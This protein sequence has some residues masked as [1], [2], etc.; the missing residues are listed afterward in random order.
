MPDGDAWG[1]TERLAADGGC[2]VS[3]GDLYGEDGAGHV[4]V[5]LV[6]PLDRLEL[7]AERLGL[8]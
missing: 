4:R 1:F 3:P 7:V 5:A 8:A 2:L 6:Q